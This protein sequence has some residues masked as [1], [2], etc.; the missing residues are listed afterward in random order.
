MKE[1]LYHIVALVAIIHDRI[2][3]LNDSFP[4][5]LSDKQL[6]F[7]VV[8]IVGM[9]LLFVVHPLFVFLT[10]RGHVLAVSWIYVFTLI[11]VLTFSVEIGQQITHT[12]VL[13]FADIVY[14]V[15]GFFIFFAAFAVIR[16]IVVLLVRWVRGGEEDD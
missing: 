10:K 13:D 11:L 6:H 12:G 16:G 7:L 14:G 15:L 3:A 2:M 9:L 5:V 1:A 8:G 4:T